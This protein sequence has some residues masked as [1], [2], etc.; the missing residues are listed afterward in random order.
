[1]GKPRQNM[2][3][4]PCKKV[5]TTLVYAASV[6]GFLLCPA[7]FDRE[8]SQTFESERVLVVEEG[9]I[10]GAP[11]IAA[12]QWHVLRGVR[13]FA[14]FAP[15]RNHLDTRI[16]SDIASTGIP[17]RSWLIFFDR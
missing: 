3:L 15:A 7:D 9:S 10:S 17:A 6:S 4:L 16:C 11:V 8:I 13:A 2:N 14:G 1:M 5:L 12:L